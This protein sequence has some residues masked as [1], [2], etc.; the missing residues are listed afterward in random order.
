MSDQ[1]IAQQI[2]AARAGELPRVVARMASGWLVVGEVQ[3]LVGYCVLMADPVVTSPNAM[4]ETQRALYAADMFRAGDAIM[5]VTGA[6]RINYETLGNVDPSLHTHIIPRYLDEPDARRRERAAVA[7]DWAMAR[8]FDPV[9]DG[10]FIAGLRVWL[11][12]ELRR[13]RAPI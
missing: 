12:V 11:G 13:P 1:T 2:A 9:A 10:P 8:R 5:A 7:Y 6:Y 4:S 3:P